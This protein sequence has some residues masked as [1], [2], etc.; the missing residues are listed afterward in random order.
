MLVNVKGVPYTFELEIS[1]TVND[2]R[3]MVANKDLVPYDDQEVVL[4]G[5][6]FSYF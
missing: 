3:K 4:G 5:T 6:R 2:L 1:N